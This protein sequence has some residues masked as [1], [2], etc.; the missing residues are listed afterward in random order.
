ME[1][2]SPASIKAAREFLEPKVGLL[3][4]NEKFFLY[5]LDEPD[6]ADFKSLLLSGKP[7]EADTKKIISTYLKRL[8]AL[9]EKVVVLADIIGITDYEELSC[10]IVDTMLREDCFTVLEKSDIEHIK[11]YVQKVKEGMNYKDALKELGLPPDVT[12]YDII[13]ESFDTD[14]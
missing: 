12:V 7:I 1:N 6:L 8:A 10:F 4:V 5:I 14:D 9:R 11:S 13:R 3:Q 2:K